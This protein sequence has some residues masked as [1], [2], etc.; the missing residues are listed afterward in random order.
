MLNYGVLVLNRAFF[1]VHITRVRRG[2]C[3]PQYFRAGQEYVPVLRE[4]VPD[5]RVEPRPRDSPVPRW[6]DNVGEH[7][8]QLHRMQQAEGGGAPGTEG[9]A[10]EPGGRAG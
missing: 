6:K 8:L 5:E 10:P 1:P 2:L 7:R 9:D 4:G 3:L